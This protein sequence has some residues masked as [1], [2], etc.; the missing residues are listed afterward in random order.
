[1]RLTFLGTRGGIAIRARPHRRHSALLVEHARGRVLIDAGD[2]WR[3]RLAALAPD[4]ILITHAHPDH[5]GAL[6]RGAPCP[7][8]ASAITCRALAALPIELRPITRMKIAGLAID[9]VPVV[10][11]LIAPAVGY[12]IDRR[13]FYVPDVVDIRNKRAAL[14]GVELYIGDGARLVRPLVR[15]TAAGQRFG[16]TSIRVQLG[17]CAG[18]GVARAIFTHCGSQVVRD[19]ARAARIV[20]ELGDARAIDARLALDGETVELTRR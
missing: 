16:H 13:V 3:G 12:R 11:S 2:D 15:R 4:A 19:P 1:M 20:R 14:A 5:A 8:Y 7:V 10:H 6:A 9:A 17:W 18:A